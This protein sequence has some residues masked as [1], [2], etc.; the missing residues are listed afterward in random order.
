MKTLTITTMLLALVLLTGCA[1]IT[2]G[3]EASLFVEVPGYSEPINCTAT[4]KKGEWEL[5]APGFVRFKKSDD[6]LQIVCEDG[7]G[8]AK[9]PVHPTRGQMIWGNILV[10][11]TIGDGV[12]ASTDAH[13][14]FPDTVRLQRES[15]RGDPLQG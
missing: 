9:R 3:T 7:D 4:N 13:W 6:P 5:T 1:S 8:I 12:D 11:G 14:E 2:K 15:C 10:G